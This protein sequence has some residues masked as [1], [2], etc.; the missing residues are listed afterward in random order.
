MSHLS[1]YWNVNLTNSVKSV[2]IK[3]SFLNVYIKNVQIK[4]TILV[5]Y[6][7]MVSKCFTACWLKSMKQYS[8]QKYNGL[9]I[10]FHWIVINNN[11]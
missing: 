3:K 2:K 1:N 7:Q 10:S 8:V 11:L 5:G 4:L 6:I 9:N